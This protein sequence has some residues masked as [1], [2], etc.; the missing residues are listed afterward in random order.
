[1]LSHSISFHLWLSF[2]SLGFFMH[3][4]MAKPFM[5]FFFSHNKSFILC[6]WW[7]SLGFFTHAHTQTFIPFLL[8]I[9]L[10]FMCLVFAVCAHRCPAKTGTRGAPRG[11]QKTRPLRLQGYACACVCVCARAC[12]QFG[13]HRN[14]VI[15]QSWATIVSACLLVFVMYYACI[16]VHVRFVCVR[17]WIWFQINAYQKTLNT[18]Q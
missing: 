4:R 3:E 9:Y 15:N 7:Y 8:R 5:L 12:L 18:C 13:I 10:S 6:L 17:M 11:F 2:Y 16:C 14:R 1:M